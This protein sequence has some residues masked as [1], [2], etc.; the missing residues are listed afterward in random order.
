MRNRRGAL[1]LELATWRRACE[2]EC[3]SQGW[4]LHRP[5]DE[6]NLDGPLSLASKHGYCGNQLQPSFFFL[7]PDACRNVVRHGALPLR[8]A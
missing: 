8:T 4:P 7:Q 1:A 2:F 5:V 6:D 3:C